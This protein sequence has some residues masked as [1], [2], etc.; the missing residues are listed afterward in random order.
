MNLNKLQARFFDEL[1]GAE[2]NVPVHATLRYERATFDIIVIPEIV[3][4][5]QFIFK[6]FNAP[7]YEPEPQV[8]GDG[9]V[10]KK[11]SIGE[12]FGAHP[13]LERAWRERAVID[14]ELKPSQTPA[15]P[16]SVRVLNT[17]IRYSGLGHRGE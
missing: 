15:Q 11:Y 8:V 2:L 10:S 14:L 4:S 1:I 7:V 12:A 16:K 3:A 6:Y 17:R 9:I 5:G 13:L